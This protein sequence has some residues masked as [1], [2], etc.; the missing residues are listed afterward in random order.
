MHWAV[1][2]VPHLWLGRYRCWEAMSRVCMHLHLQLCFLFKDN[3]SQ[4]LKTTASVLFRTAILTCV[5]FL[6][7]DHVYLTHSLL[8]AL[9]FAPCSLIIWK[10]NL[11]ASLAS[12]FLTQVSLMKMYCCITVFYHLIRSNNLCYVW[13]W[14]S[15]CVSEVSE[16]CKHVPLQIVVLYLPVIGKSSDQSQPPKDLVK[17]G[18]NLR[19]S[20]WKELRSACSEYHRRPH[21]TSFHYLTRIV[22]LRCK[23][24]I[25]KNKQVL[26]SLVFNRSSKFTY[27]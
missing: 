1:P 6:L 8:W 22:L 4:T 17:I 21:D 23:M 26:V 15:G 5:K 3:L 14:F 9:L 11:Y 24:K 7:V 10:H 13:A 25:K 2:H 20:Y 18:Y 27:L 16:Y 12:S 19:M